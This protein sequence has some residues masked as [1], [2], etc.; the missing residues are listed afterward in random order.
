MS[1]GW[2][3]TMMADWQIAEAAEASMLS[4][5]ALGVSLGLALD[6]MIPHSRVLGDRPIRQAARAAPGTAGGGR[7]AGPTGP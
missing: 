2:D 7:P 4:F 5:T 3:S 6:A 1:S